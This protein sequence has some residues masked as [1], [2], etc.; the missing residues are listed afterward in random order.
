MENFITSQHYIN[1]EIVAEKIAAG[2]FEVQVS[3]EFEIGGE[4]FR[5]VMDGHHSLAAAIEAGVEPTIIEQDATE[6]D[7]VALLDAGDVEAFLAACWMDGEY[8]YAISGKAVW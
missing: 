3:P 7:R 1:N 6:N 4:T 5:V 8:Q 2:D